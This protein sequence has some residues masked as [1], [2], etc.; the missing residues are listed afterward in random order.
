LKE[1]MIAPVFVGKSRIIWIPI[2]ADEII[3]F[4]IN[5]YQI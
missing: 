5:H 3:I 2:Y 1:I 4:D